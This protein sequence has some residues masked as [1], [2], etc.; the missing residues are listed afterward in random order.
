MANENLFRIRPIRG[1]S[2]LPQVQQALEKRTELHSR[3]TL[4]GIWKLTDKLNAAE[5]LPPEQLA[6]RRKRRCILAVP[7]YLL[8]IFILVP[9]LME[10]KELLSLLIPG[11]AL[12][13]FALSV[14]WRNKRKLLALLCLLPAVILCWGG[15]LSLELR[16]LLFL[17]IP[18]CLLGLA[19]LLPRG[20]KGSRYQQAAKNLLEQQ[21]RI[22]EDAEISVNF[23]PEMLRISQAEEKEE[24]L[25]T[26]LDCAIETADLI[27]LAFGQQAILLQKQELLQG[28]LED[29]R[30]L[31]REKSRHFACLP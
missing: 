8:A 12:L 11:L 4:P 6:A 2:L 26:A 23:G 21:S 27:L 17:D 29:V 18:L 7:A 14:L 31:L 30:N 10:P 19:A 9:A 5:T 20:R 28:S 1:E 3:E 22:P 13:L 15:A 25:Y 16:N 24:C